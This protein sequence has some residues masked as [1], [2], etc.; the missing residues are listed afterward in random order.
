MPDTLPDTPVQPSAQ[1][2]QAQ[3]AV[4]LVNLG[5]PDAPTAGA[6]RRYLRQFLSDPRVVEIPRW[7]WWPI[8]YGLVLPLRPARSA[9]KYAA[10]W[11]EQGSPLLLNSARQAAGLQAALRR[12]GCEVRV[13]AAKRYG[14]PGLDE[15]LQRLARDGCERILIL[16]GYPQYS[17]TTTASLVDAVADCQRAMRNL[18]ALRWIKDYPDHPLY[19]QALAASIEEYWTCHG[20]G[21]RLIMSFHGIPQRSV[22]LG[23]PYE[24]QCRRTAAALARRLGLED[25]EY[26]VTF[27]SRFGKAQWLQPYTATSVRHLAQEGVGR[28]DLVCPGFISDCLETLEEIDMEVRQDFLAAGGAQFH[29]IPCLNARPDWIAAMAELA[30]QHLAG[31]P[32]GAHQGSGIGD[33]GSGIS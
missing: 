15:T 13:E 19:I 17:A 22:Q 14:R 25:S 20:R 27:Q 33:Q 31:W 5:S 30:A 3:T 12:Q 26:L 28:V 7:I 32:C 1:A 4:I 18:P 8:L 9:R 23:D 16:P 2:R 21:E 10:I 24:A 6:L 11:Q 29:Y